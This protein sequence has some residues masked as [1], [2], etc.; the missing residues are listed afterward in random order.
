MALLK[1]GDVVRAPLDGTLR[2]FYLDSPIPGTSLDRT[3]VEVSGWL[4][5]ARSQAREVQLWDEDIL[6]RT[7]PVNVPRP[8]VVAEHTDAPERTGFWSLTGT[9]G[10]ERNFKLDLRALFDDGTKAELGSISGTRHPIASAETRFSPVLLTS[11]GRTGT[12]LLMGLLSAH[13]TIVA[14]RT[15][16]YETFPARYWL[17]LLQVLAEP[18]KNG[19]SSAAETYALDLSHVGA[20][21]FHTA[22]LTNDPEVAELF[23]RSYVERLARFCQES[24]DEF[25]GAVAAKQGKPTAELFVE[26]AHP[27]HVPRIARDLY[28]AAREI[29]LV[30]DFRDL[31]CSVLAFNEK[32]GT[33][34]FG[35][36]QFETDEEY[37]GWIGIGA[38]W[39]VNAWRARKTTS[40][41]VRYEELARRPAE[42]LDGM[43]GYLEVDRDPELVDVLVRGA[44][45][46]PDF[47]DHRTSESIERSIGRWRRDLPPSLRPAVRRAL[48]EALSEFGYEADG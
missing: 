36:A 39:L 13:P 41:L 46:H 45:E 19:E 47:T 10:L 34:E 9:L 20:N 33:L 6:L 35:R 40:H 8:D 17:H 37:V 3:T 29:F 1:I 24:I 14:D 12:T 48:A 18:A 38:G 25:Y 30:R 16:P 5:G 4:I 31:I 28:P 15:F 11:L 32:R 43:L 7:I 23:G 22:P 27:D 2:A 26:K 44:F 21:P 42:T